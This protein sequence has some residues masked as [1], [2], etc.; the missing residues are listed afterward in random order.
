MKAYSCSSQTLHPQNKYCY[1]Q[2]L[3]GY[4]DK[5]LQNN[6]LAP[7]ATAPVPLL[8]QESD[9]QQYMDNTEHDFRFH[10]SKE[11]PDDLNKLCG[12]CY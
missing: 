1:S 9:P 10:P 7:A 11:K 4:L 12:L 5:F 3:S 8:V 6:F 2:K